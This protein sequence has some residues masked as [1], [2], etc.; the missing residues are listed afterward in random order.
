M[1]RNERREIADIME[2]A[3]S[4]IAKG[5]AEFCCLVFSDIQG[6][7]ESRMKARRIFTDLFANDALELS[8]STDIER[9]WFQTSDEGSYDD[10]RLPLY[11]ER[12][13]E[14]RSRRVLGLC[15]AAHMVRQG[16]I[17]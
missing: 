14:L 15:W 12:Q 16:V 6:D 13:R 3:A 7:Y 8:N 2:R 17:E 5:A 11:A 4:R 1:T 9:A 10:A